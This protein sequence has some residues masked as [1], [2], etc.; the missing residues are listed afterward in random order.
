MIFIG[1]LCLA[2]CF[3][4]QIPSKLGPLFRPSTRLPLLGQEGKCLLFL[5]PPLTRR[6]GAEGDG[7]VWV[8][9]AHPQQAGAPLPPF[10]TPTPSRAGGDIQKFFPLLS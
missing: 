7:V 4:G 8:W 3:R 9:C 1:S 10:N 2:A 6:G 5:S